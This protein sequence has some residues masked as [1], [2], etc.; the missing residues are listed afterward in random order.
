MGFIVIAIVMLL[1]AA[2]FVAWPLLRK[3]E[4]RSAVADFK[5]VRE[6]RLAELERDVESGALDQAAYESARKDL[7]AELAQSE[8]SAQA[9]ATGGSHRRGIAAGVSLV[10]VIALSVGLYLHLGDWKTGYYGQHEATQQT[11]ESMVSQLAERLKKEPN[12]L[13]GWLMLGRS[14]TVM[15]KYSD[16]VEA[17][18]HANTISGGQD[19]DVLASLGEAMVLADPQHLNQTEAKIFD[20]ALEGDPANIK[21][22]WYGGLLASHSGDDATAIKRW[23]QLL[24]LDTPA[25]FQAVIKEQISKL[26]GDPTPLG[27]TRSP[28]LASG[29]QVQVNLSIDPALKAQLKPGE[30]LFVFIHEPGKGGP[31]LAVKRLAATFPQTVTLS[32]ANAMIPGVHLADH[33]QLEV[34]ARVSASGSPVAEAGDMTGKVVISTDKQSPVANIRVTDVTK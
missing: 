5:A 28:A 10:F 32:D 30:S 2:G 12:D 25:R 18:T 14:Y 6:S 15:G 29:L 33:K 20:K 16:A 11:V 3:R 8:A 23:R 1:V 4:A 13:K 34:V 26:G 19:P 22:L 24:A 17:L 7:E 27:G 9:I 31:P 21:A